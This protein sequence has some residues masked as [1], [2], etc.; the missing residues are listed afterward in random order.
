MQVVS[1]G[2]R[3]TI[4]PGG[5]K[6]FLPGGW[7]NEF[8]NTKLKHQRMRNLE[9]REQKHQERLNEIQELKDRFG[10]WD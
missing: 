1:S 6:A 5:R 9:I 2:R 8:I 10:I 3:Y 7:T 4:A